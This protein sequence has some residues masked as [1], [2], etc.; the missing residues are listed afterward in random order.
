MNNTDLI[1]YF[2]CEWDKIPLFTLFQVIAWYRSLLFR[3]TCPQKWFLWIRTDSPAK[4]IANLSLRTGRHCKAGC[5]T[6]EHNRDAF[7][8]SSSLRCNNCPNCPHCQLKGIP[9]WEINFFS[10]HIIILLL[11][12][13]FTS[14]LHEICKCN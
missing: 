7:N 2:L 11:L 1:I 12:L 10:P 5:L 3:V 4:C 9:N 13:L 8:R 6:N 14:I